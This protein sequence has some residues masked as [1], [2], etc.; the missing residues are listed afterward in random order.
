M[1][2]GN[3]QN[4]INNSISAVIDEPMS[5]RVT[6]VRSEKAQK[7]YNKRAKENEKFAR[8]KAQILSLF[9]SAGVSPP[10]LLWRNEILDWATTIIA[11]LV[12]KNQKS[13]GINVPIES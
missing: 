11:R 5:K 9:Q 12:E 10:R 13:S 3:V 4:P 8:L 2:T 7:S 1:S 6:V